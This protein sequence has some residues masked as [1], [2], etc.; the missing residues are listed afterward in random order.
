MKVGYTKP[1]VSRVV[2]ELDQVALTF[3]KYINYWPNSPHN[4]L[5]TGHGCVPSDP[6]QCQEIPT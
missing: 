2:L 4:T 6:A 1:T 5:P 3:C